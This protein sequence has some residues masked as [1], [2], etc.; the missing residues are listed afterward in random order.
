MGF[1]YRCASGTEYK[2]NVCGY[3]VG[4]SEGWAF[5]RNSK[6]RI[7][8]YSQPLCMSQEAAEAGVKGFYQ[9]AY[10]PSCDRLRKVIT[11]EYETPR[12]ESDKHKWFDEFV[13]LIKKLCNGEPSEPSVERSFEHTCPACG[14]KLYEHLD[15]LSCPRCKKGLFKM[16]DHWVC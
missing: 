7:K 15:K 4:T 16:G 8:T 2:C 6:G 14:G 5:Y 12:F 9:G 3:I 13:A 1:D 11:E 10:C